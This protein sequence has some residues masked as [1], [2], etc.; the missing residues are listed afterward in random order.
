MLNANDG[1]VE[2]KGAAAELVERRRNQRSSHFPI[3]VNV[4]TFRR[5]GL[6]YSSVRLF[7]IL[8][9]LAVLLRAQAPQKIEKVCSTEDVLFF[10]LTCSEEDPCPVF[11]ELASVEPNGSSL[12]LTGNLHTVNTTLFGLLLKSDDGGKTWTEPAKRIRSAALEQI[13]FADFQH[14]FIGGVKLEPLPRDP[15][16]MTTADGGTTWRQ[17]PLFEETQ[18]GSI[19]QFWFESATNGQLILDESE[20]GAKRYERYETKDGGAGWEKQETANHEMPLAQA[21]PREYA[22]WR[23][24]LDRVAYRVE[25]K[26]A[27]A[28][29]T[30]E[31]VASFVIQPGDCR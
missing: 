15:F 25:R 8:S 7:A 23:I 27:N 17:T 10:G 29:E 9:V 24:R 11:L 19:Q 14:G 13:Q 3:V 1:R 21:R 18:S 6:Q 28:S 30:W 31:T 22:S 2:G 20:G 5:A 12:F 4:R 26:A 16:L